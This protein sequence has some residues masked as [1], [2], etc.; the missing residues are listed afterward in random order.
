MSVKKKEKISL[1]VLE[2]I[3]EVEIKRRVK[4]LGNILRNLQQWKAFV[5]D[6]GLVSITIEGEEYFI[7]DLE[8]GID[9]LPKRQRQAV[10]LMCIMDMKE[11]DAARELGFEK[12]TTPAQQYCKSGLRKLV[13]LHL[14]R[15]QWDREDLVR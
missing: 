15:G 8:E 3:P 13:A 9:L 14:S 4:L 6:E 2:G 5:E 11:A 1:D 12:W 7:Y 10:E